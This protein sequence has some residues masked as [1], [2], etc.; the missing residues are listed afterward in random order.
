VDYLSSFISTDFSDYVL[1]EFHKKSNVKEELQEDEQIKNVEI[2]AIEFDWIFW[3]DY[4]NQFI[5]TLAESSNDKL[6]DISTVKSIILFLWKKYFTRMFRLQLIPFLFYLL[7]V[8]I[9]ISYIY[10]R[11]VDRF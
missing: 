5:K 9:Y 1:K 4:S 11:Y 6:F 10:E 2:S 3:G 8:I 7:F